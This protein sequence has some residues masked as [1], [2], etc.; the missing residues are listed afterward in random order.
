ME[1]IK[2]QIKIRRKDLHLTQKELADLA[3]LK[4]V[5]ISAIEKGERTPSLRA[6]IRLAKALGCTVNDLLYNVA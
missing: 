3:G 6:I 4:Q 5:T 2:D 1:Q